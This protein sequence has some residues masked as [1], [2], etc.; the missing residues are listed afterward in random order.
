MEQKKFGSDL[1]ELRN[2]KYGEYPY[3][4]HLEMVYTIAKK[5]IYL[6]NNDEYSQNVLAACWLHDTIEDCGITYN[7]IKNNFNEEIAEIV[8]SVTN[9]IR[10]RNRKSR[11]EPSYPA[12]RSNICANFVKI[13]DRIANMEFSKE[14]GSSMFKKYQ[15]E[16]KEFRK[17]IEVKEYELYDMWNYLFKI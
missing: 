17:N 9:D 4:K 12:I 16:L 6:L 13:C 14:Q 3:S 5:F 1:H 10:G 7:D 2:Y 11:I 15:K 8:I